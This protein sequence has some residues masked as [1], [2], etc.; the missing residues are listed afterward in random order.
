MRKTK[1]ISAIIVT[2]RFFSGESLVY[3]HFTSKSLPIAF[4]FTFTVLNPWYASVN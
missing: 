3:R 4:Y 2:K 1:S